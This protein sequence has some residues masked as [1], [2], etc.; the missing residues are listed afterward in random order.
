MKILVITARYYPE[1]FSITNICENI[2]SQGH[3][4]TVV[5]GKP[6]YGYWKIID[7]YEQV[8]NETING[9]KVLRL[10]E[11][12]RKK[13][14]VGLIRNYTS[15]YKEFGKFFRNHKEKY[16]VVISHVMSPIF[17]MHGLKKY[18]KKNKIPHIHY[19]LD[20]WPESL[21][22][23]SYLTRFNPIFQLV[24]VYSKKVY[25]SCDYIT[26]ASPSVEKYF[27]DYLGLSNLKFKQIFQPTLTT[28]PEINRVRKEQYS[29][30]HIRILYCGTIARFHRLDLIL[31]ALKII[32]DSGIN[33]FHLDIVG[34][35][36]ELDN[37]MAL[38]KNLK[39]D[40][41]VTFHGRVPKE[42]TQK[43]YLAADILYVPLEDNSATS[44]MIPQKLIE[45][46]MYNR[47][48]FGMLTGDG[49][50]ILAT[51]SK[52]NF[53]AEQSVNSLVDTFN[54]IIKSQ[55]TFAIC[56]RQNR[57]YFED[58]SRFRIDVICSELL[59]VCS[60]VINEYKHR[61]KKE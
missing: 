32:V 34:S 12:P 13:G 35:G 51:A 53:I 7:G 5:T 42:D 8:Y 31:K 14:I 38:A 60:I 61:G 22:A 46:L 52:Y 2:A 15:I 39:L 37:I 1:Q 26:F 27:T 19:G 54:K 49:R 18:C 28:I 20:L 50:E 4:V 55:S 47:P 36:S 57:T 11:R 59:E 24:K 10:N 43:Y 3:D 6:N 40:N 45:Y 30:N 44:K 29:P 56:G 16:D 48:I 17:S 23:S 33:L 41:C 21:I 58:N 25:S 9:V